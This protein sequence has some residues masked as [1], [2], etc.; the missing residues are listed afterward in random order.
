MSFAQYILSKLS[1]PAR[2]RIDDP[3]LA[4]KAERFATLN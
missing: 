3:D 1:T 4:E 2:M